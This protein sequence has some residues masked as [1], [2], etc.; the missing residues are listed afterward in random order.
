MH[1]AYTA[2]GGRAVYHLAPAVGT[3]G[4]Q[5]IALE[6]A[7]PLWKDTLEEFLRSIQVLP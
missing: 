3:D 6:A 4:H 1:E 5:L 7:V 2:A